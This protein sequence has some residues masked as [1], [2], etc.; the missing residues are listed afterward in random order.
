MVGIALHDG[1]ADERLNLA[2]GA[3]DGIEAASRQLV[4]HVERR[5]EV[6]QRDRSRGLGEL[7]G[8]DESRAGRSDCASAIERLEDRPV[9]L[10][11]GDELG[12]HAVVPI[13]VRGPRP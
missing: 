12:E 7:D 1:V 13:A 6:A 8:G 5:A 10:E 2:V 11:G 4:V 3:G 9:L